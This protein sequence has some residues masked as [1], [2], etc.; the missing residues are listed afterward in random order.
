M[1][2]SDVIKSRSKIRVFLFFLYGKRLKDKINLFIY[3]TL[4]RVISI[5]LYLFFRKLYARFMLKIY[6]RMPKLTVKFSYGKF[7]CKER[8]DGW[9][10]I[11]PNYEIEVT[12]LIVKLAKNLK[13]DEFFIDVGAYI[14]RYTIIIGNLANCKILSIEPGP[15]NFSVLRENIKLNNLDSKVILANVALSDR[16]G[17]MVFYLGNIISSGHSFLRRDKNMKKIKVTTK[18]LDKLLEELRIPKEKVK[19]IKIDVEGWEYYVLKGAFKTLKHRPFIIFEAWNEEKLNKVKS[20]LEKF[21]YQI[22]KIVNGNYFAHP[23]KVSE[24]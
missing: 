21:N 13:K 15:E 9:H 6:G 22:S 18:T 20:I 11:K 23:L 16:E 3:W 7:I 17:E 12:K 8:S 2:L 5:P 10:I 24:Y 4:V 19:L 1:D 14:G